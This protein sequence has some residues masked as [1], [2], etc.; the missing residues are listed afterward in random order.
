MDLSSQLR[1]ILL[2]VG[3]AVLAAMY[4][5][6]KRRAADPERRADVWRTDNHLATHPTEAEFAAN[7]IPQLDEQAFEVP[8]YMRKQGHAASLDEF[9]EPLSEGVEPDDVEFVTVAEAVSAAR[10]ELTAQA[11]EP[12]LADHK[13]D[14]FTMSD[15]QFSAVADEPSV[16]D[17]PA[18]AMSVQRSAPEIE[19][20]HESEVPTIPAVS[21]VELDAA[22]VRPVNQRNNADAVAPTLSEAVVPA[23]HTTAPQRAT[24]HDQ[25]PLSPAARRKIVALRLA[26]NERV[27][28]ARLQA[29]LHAERLVHGRF[30]IFHRE[31]EGSTVFSLASMVEPGT[32]D[33]EL[34]LQQQFPGVTLFMLLPGPLDGLIAY[35]QMLSCAQRL[36]HATGGI[37]Q[38]ERGNP[39]TTQVMERLR[40]EVLDFQHLMSGIA[41]P[42]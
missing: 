26:I 11:S 30:N 32:F 14:R 16:I 38:D 15:M 4:F 25:K 31:H 42:G 35:D 36:A 39:L 22:H 20:P 17:E 37:V 1:I 7:D 12:V 9:A 6:G 8:A 40:E 23:A 3:V 18:S 24:N 41:E 19:W 10:D 5:F 13:A 33:I 29:L 28:G 34:M 2:L 21:V 27:A